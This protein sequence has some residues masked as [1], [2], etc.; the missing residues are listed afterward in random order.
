MPT[1]PG[2]NHD[3]RPTNGPATDG[4]CRYRYVETEGEILIYDADREDAWIQA[5]ESVDIEAWR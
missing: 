3:E 5:S 1:E 2:G 4:C